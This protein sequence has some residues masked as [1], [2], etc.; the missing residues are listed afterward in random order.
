MQSE[1][2]LNALK[3]A[4]EEQSQ[5][6]LADRLGFSIGKT[7]YILKGL[8]EKGLLKAERF[9]NSENKMAYRYVLTPQGINERIRLT[10]KFIVRKKQ[11]YE[12]LQ[13]DLLKLKKE[14]PSRAD[15]LNNKKL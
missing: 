6:S 12:E 3:Y 1:T 8:M 14:K 4:P 7:N 5:R 10:E 13:Q 2:L 11:E 15:I 9:V